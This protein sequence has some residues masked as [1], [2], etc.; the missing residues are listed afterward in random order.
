NVVNMLKTQ[1]ADIVVWAELNYTGGIPEG[2]PYDIWE[3]GGQDASGYI[4]QQAFAQVHM[5]PSLTYTGRGITV[6]LIDTGVAL[7]HPALTGHLAAGWDMV[8]DDA[9]PN[10]EPGGAGWGHGTHIAGI[11]AHMAPESVILPVRVLNPQGRGNSFVVAYAI[12]WAVNQ[13]AQVINLSLGTDFDSQILREAVAWATARGVVVVAAAGNR[14]A[15]TPHYPAAYPNV[16]G[17]TAVDATNR[18]ASFAG[19]GAGWV[20]VAAPGVGITS[21]IVGD[22]GYGYASWS[23]TSMSTAFVSAAAALERQQSPAASAAQVEGSIVASADNLDA[24]NP[25]YAGQLGGG[26]LNVSRLLDIPETTVT[27]TATPTATPTPT[28][29]STSTPT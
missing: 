10:D 6:A 16:V 4:N 23:G 24:L 22:Q 8:D 26:L 20:D 13:G 1:D 14:A 5:P 7:A 29:T 27:P 19:Y 9:I 25:V 2:N 15:S 17:V 28:A 12:E 21:T 3:W 11:I 18:K